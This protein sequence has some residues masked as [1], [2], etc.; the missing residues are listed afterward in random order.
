MQSQRHFA[1]LFNLHRLHGSTGA[2]YRSLTLDVTHP[3]V[4]QKIARIFD[5]PY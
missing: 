4:N 3:R 1:R 2:G 5:N